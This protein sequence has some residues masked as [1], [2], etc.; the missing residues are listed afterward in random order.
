MRKSY[1]FCQEYEQE[2][3]A[4]ME[5][6]RAELTDKRFGFGSQSLRQTISEWRF[7]QAYNTVLY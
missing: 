2:I 6:S 1:A 4:H 7:Y 5:R 3:R